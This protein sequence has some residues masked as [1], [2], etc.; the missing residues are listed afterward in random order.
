MT[1][2][3]KIGRDIIIGKGFSA[4]HWSGPVVFS[5]QAVYLCPNASLAQVQLGV[6]SAALVGGL[7][8]A[9]GGAIAGTVSRLPKESRRWSQQV[10]DMRELPVAIL[11]APDWPVRKRKRPVITIPRTE[12]QTIQRKGGRLLF[13]ALGGTFVLGMSLFGRTRIVADVRSLGWQIVE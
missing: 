5:S 10:I 6:D 1:E 4:K 2:Y 13:E 11:T 3:K 12:V 7:F 9:V 8:G